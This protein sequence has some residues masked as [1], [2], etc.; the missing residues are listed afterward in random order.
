MHY[1]IIAN[2]FHDR[3]ILDDPALPEGVSFIRGSLIDWTPDAPLVFR[4]NCDAENPPRHYMDG[5]MPVWSAELL[6][7]FGRAGVDNIQPFPAIITDDGEGM[8][9]SGYFAINVVGS[10]A[11]AD[12]ST[13][14]WKKIGEHPTGLPLL[15]FQKLVLDARKS[16]D[17]LLFRLAENPLQ[18]IVHEGVLDQLSESAPADG[19]GISA[20][21]LEESP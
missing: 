7:A 12:L 14:Q 21:E 4:S 15:A 9:W 1:S 2:P 17:L 13:S 11:A 19:W 20:D 10:V 3:G 16:H 18:L 8:E 5:V 6:D